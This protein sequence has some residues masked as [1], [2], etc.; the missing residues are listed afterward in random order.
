MEIPPRILRVKD[1][2]ELLGVSRST[3]YSWISSGIFP[4]P[5]R[6]GP[7]VVGW[8]ATAIEEWLRD[9]DVA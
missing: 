9:R 2:V 1:V 7:N 5:A 4:R 3:L 6:L 8:P